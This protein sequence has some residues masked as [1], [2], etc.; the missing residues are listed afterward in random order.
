[1]CQ[2]TCGTP[3][4]T[5]PFRN[6]FSWRT[7]GQGATH[8][9]KDLMFV[10]LVMRNFLSNFPGRG[11]G[12]VGGS[13]CTIRML[14]IMHVLPR[15]IPCT[16]G[17]R[18]SSTEQRRSPAPVSAASGCTRTASRGP[19]ASL[20]EAAHAARPKKKKNSRWAGGGVGRG[21]ELSRFF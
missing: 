3:G 21:T 17:S 9:P 11:G 8:P 7:S 14:L 20:S 10:I 2:S 13:T 4:L 5:T 1:M 16:G 6:R 18:R 15:C 19:A 12:G